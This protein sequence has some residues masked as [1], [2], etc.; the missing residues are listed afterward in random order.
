M[1]KIAAIQKIIA[2]VA[3]TKKIMPVAAKNLKTK[4]KNAVAKTKKKNS[5][6]N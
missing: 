3:M 6:I 1:T 2:A 5:L 4:I